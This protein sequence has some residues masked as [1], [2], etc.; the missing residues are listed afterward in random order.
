MSKAKGKLYRYQNLINRVVNWKSYLLK[1]I[2][3]F[4]KEF[5]FNI[6]DFGKISVLKNML[7]PFRENFLDDIYFK[8]IPKEIFNKNQHP[9]IVDIGA[10]VGFFSLAAFSKYPKAKF[11][12]L[13]RI[14]IV[15]KYCKITDKNLKDLTG[16]FI[17]WP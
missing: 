6:R 10:N 15:L 1:K 17:I 7:G 8:H 13:S 5:E 2:L 11:T 14:H 12:H 3:G 16:I 9:V 4:N